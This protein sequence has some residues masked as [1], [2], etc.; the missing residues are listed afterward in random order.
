MI[1]R[2]AIGYI[3]A[4]YASK[5]ES[6]LLED[7]PLASL[8]FAGR[9]R[10][11]DFAISNMVNAGIR[12]I[13]L[14][15]PG[16]Y[17]SLI[18]HLSSGKDW[19]LDRKK[20]GMYFLPGSAY[21]TSKQ[22]MRFLLRDIIASK[23][24]FQ[25][26]DMPYVVMCGTNIIFNIDLSAIIDAHEASGAQIT[27]VYVRAERSHDDSA[28]ALNIGDRGRVA[29][30][31]RGVAYGDAKFLD[32]FVINRDLL[33]DVIDNYETFD[34]LDIFEALGSEFG[35]LDVCSYEFKGAA[36]GIFGENT[37]YQR[38]MDLL[39]PDLSDQLFCPERPI[40]TKAHDAPPAKFA[41]GSNASNSLISA[42]C[43][44]EGTVRGSILS[45]NVVVEVGASVVDSIIMQSCV[46]RS[47]ARVEN[48]IIDKNNEVPAH[49]EL[50]GT[51][52]AILVVG[53][54]PVKTLSVR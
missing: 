8:P 44:V 48:A 21:G 26:S 10:L 40:L 35:R 50:R 4:N 47:G 41:A 43:I 2:K 54:G 46:I 14:V 27:M 45:R 38:S 53:K 5:H 23:T 42:N 24:L 13:G 7:R 39:N 11:V 1:N 25:R 34:Y 9:Y 49:T 12:T 36:L 31:S 3:T 51:P 28:V 32:C 29:S 6:A 52:E 33:L 17:R 22:G 16:N 18:D 37:Y 30:V 19:G 15:M 20:G